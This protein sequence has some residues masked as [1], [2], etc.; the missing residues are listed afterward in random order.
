LELKDVLP[1]F[2]TNSWK[3]SCKIKTPKIPSSKVVLE[4]STR[5]GAWPH[6]WE[7]RYTNI[8]QSV[9]VCQN[10]ALCHRI[11]ATVMILDSSSK[12]VDTF[13]S[14]QSHLYTC[15]WWSTPPKPW[16]FR[17]VQTANKTFSDSASKMTWTK[18]RR[19]KS[20]K[21]MK[22]QLPAECMKSEVCN[23]KI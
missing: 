16:R 7:L 10:K 11:P 20:I 9:L 13:F 8:G 14:G 3:L 22:I 21:M 23:N 15:G 5:E 17:S 1:T 18:M 19:Q 6:I 12:N 2:Q 4:V